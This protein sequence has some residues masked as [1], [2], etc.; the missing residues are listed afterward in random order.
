MHSAIRDKR[1]NKFKIT[2]TTFFNSFSTKPLSQS[3]SYLAKIH[4]HCRL[5][6][7][8][9]FQLWEHVLVQRGGNVENNNINS[10]NLKSSF[11]ETSGKF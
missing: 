6:Y 3:Q 11:Q 4:V 2:L 5:Q 1:I 7:N 9:F 8:F 10:A